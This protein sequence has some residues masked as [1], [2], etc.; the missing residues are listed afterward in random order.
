[1]TADCNHHEPH[2]WLTVPYLAANAEEG[3]LLRDAAQRQLLSI[4]PEPGNLLCFTGAMPGDFDHPDNWVLR[5]AHN[6]RLHPDDM[7][8][9]QA[10]S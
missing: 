7:P 9:F 2:I 4:C 10:V 5:R 3:R 6:L 8:I 1:M